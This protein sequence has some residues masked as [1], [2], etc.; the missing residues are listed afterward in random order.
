MSDKNWS[1]LNLDNKWSLISSFSNK[2]A[3]ENCNKKHKFYVHLHIY[4]QHELRQVFET[5]SEWNINFF[6]IITISGKENY[7]IYNLL[8][9]F[10]NPYF[11][12]LYVRNF[13]YDILP[14]IKALKFI[15]S[16]D[17]LVV[18]I[19]TKRIH[20]EL[21][22]KWSQCCLKGVL[23]CTPHIISILSHFEKN[24]NVLMLGPEPLYKSAKKFM[25]NNDRFCT[26]MLKK[27]F[28]DN[29]SIP[30]DWGFFAGSMFWARKKSLIQ[31]VDIFNSLELKLRDNGSSQ[32]GSVFH[33]AERIFGVL[34]IAYNGTICTVDIDS[35]NN[36]T[37]Q[38]KPV[39]SLVPLTQSF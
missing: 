18:K 6:L 12:V 17:A 16:E 23:P 10:Q 24:K 36:M 30:S 33:A 9:K 25:Y 14:F 8:V 34:P 31:L 11:K 3:S 37:L 15:E 27:I 39:P 5:L 38:N 20:E 22:T 35:A 1:Q 32:Q 26:T 7:F 4:Y 29:R 2:I 19:H 28:T 13:G 21:G